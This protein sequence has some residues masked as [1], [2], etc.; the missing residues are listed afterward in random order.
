M[1][2]EDYKFTIKFDKPKRNYTQVPNVLIDNL[3]HCIKPNHL[4]VLL[5]FMRSKP[6]YI[7]STK[8][9]ADLMGIHPKNMRKTIREM[10]ADGLIQFYE[11]KCHLQIHHP[12]YDLQEKRKLK[13]ENNKNGYRKAVKSIDNKDKEKSTNAV[14]NTAPEGVKNT[15]VTNRSKSYSNDHMGVNNT[16][17]TI[18]KNTTPVNP[19]N[20]Q[21]NKG[22]EADLTHPNNTNSKTILNSNNVYKEIDKENIVNNSNSLIGEKNSLK[23]I[24][25]NNQFKNIYQSLKWE[26]LDISNFSDGYIAHLVIEKKIDDKPM[27]LNNTK[28]E[29]FLFFLVQ[30][31]L[32]EDTPPNKLKDEVMSQLKEK[33]D[34]DQIKKFL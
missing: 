32:N 11:G 29:S 26:E 3:M 4:K 13:K 2:K 9:I 10:E 5:I 21:E 24:L 12:N 27:D 22:T 19:P 6:D 14:N 7:F 8:V 33:G 17:D 1:K 28:K 18:V 23:V 16:A 25:K 34:E 15:A 30:Y 31:S 20:P